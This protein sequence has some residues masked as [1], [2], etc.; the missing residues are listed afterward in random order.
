MEEDKIY[1]LE[2]YI[3]F[4]AANGQNIDQLNVLGTEY[5]IDYFTVGDNPSTIQNKV[6]FMVY[7]DLNQDF[8]NKEEVR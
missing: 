2:K 4:Y 6:K 8:K 7:I 5:G 1:D 3:I